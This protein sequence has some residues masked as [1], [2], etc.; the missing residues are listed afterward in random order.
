MFGACKAVGLQLGGAA[1][2]PPRGDLVGGRFA[3][4]RMGA[5]DDVLRHACSPELSA[6]ELEWSGSADYVNPSPGANTADD[7]YHCV[8]WLQMTPATVISEITGPFDTPLAV[9][10]LSFLGSV[11]VLS[12]F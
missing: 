8:G 6:P 11:N 2:A 1:V 9:P 5:T 4:L 3:A 10:Q 7:F 12:V